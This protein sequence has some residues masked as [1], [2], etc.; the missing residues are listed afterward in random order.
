MVLL[1]VIRL[2]VVTALPVRRK[3]RSTGSTI[4]AVVGILLL[5]VPVLVVLILRIA[6]VLTLRLPRRSVATVKRLDVASAIV[7]RVGRV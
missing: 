1:A 2:V 5:G 3:R 6:S 4:S 7:L